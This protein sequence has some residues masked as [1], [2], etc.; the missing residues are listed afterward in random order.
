MR[1]RLQRQG[2]FA[3]RQWTGW[4]HGQA[5]G[6]VHAGHFLGQWLALAGAPQT[7]VQLSGAQ[8]AQLLRG[9]HLAGFHAHVPAGVGNAGPVVQAGSRP[10][11]VLLGISHAF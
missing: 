10:S 1:S 8:G 9:D 6:I 2:A 5:V 4:R 7:Q 11:S 3:S